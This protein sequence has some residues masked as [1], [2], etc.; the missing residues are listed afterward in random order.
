[1]S[2]MYRIS[3]DGDEL[4]YQVVASGNYGNTV[5]AQFASERDAREL[6]H[7]LNGGSGPHLMGQLERMVARLDDL[8]ATI[9][10]VLSIGVRSK[11]NEQSN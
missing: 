5:V 10:R 4:W 9:D 3:N 7:F 8:I 11:S 6:V 1:M 2:W